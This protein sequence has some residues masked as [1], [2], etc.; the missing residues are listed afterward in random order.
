MAVQSFRESHT[1]VLQ[2]GCRA[3]ADVARGETWWWVVAPVGRARGQPLTAPSERPPRQYFCRTT[4]AQISGM[5][6]T[7]A[8]P[9]VSW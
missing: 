1:R 8:P 3:L 6:E 7:S 9:V 4:I 2:Q 5:I